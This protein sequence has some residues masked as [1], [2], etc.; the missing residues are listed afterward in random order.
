[1]DADLPDNM[2]A[3]AA[4]LMQEARK[5]AERMAAARHSDQAICAVIFSLT[6]L[7][8]SLSELRNN[9]DARSLAVERLQSAI[10]RERGKARSGSRRYDFNRH[11]ALYQALKTI[12]IAYSANGAHGR[13]TGG[14]IDQ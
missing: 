11:V 5:H 10:K 3:L 8:T 13:G 12:G 6:G 1:M 4:R 9:E 2:K 7:E 14:K